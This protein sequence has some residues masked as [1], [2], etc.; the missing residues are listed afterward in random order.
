MK[1]RHRDRENPENEVG[2]ILKW[3]QVAYGIADLIDE[4]KY[5]DDKESEEYIA[6]LSERRGTDENRVKAIARHIAEDG[7]KRNENG[8]RTTFF[9]W[10]YADY[11]FC[12]DHAVEIE[13]ALNACPEVA[14]AKIDG[15]KVEITVKEA[16][17][18]YS[19]QPS[20]KPVRDLDSEEDEEWKS[21]IESGEIKPIEPVGESTKESNTDLTKIGFEQSELGGVKQRFKNNIEA[22]KLV[23][24]L[25]NSQKEATA[26]EKKVLANTSVGAAWRKRSTNIMSLGKANM[27]N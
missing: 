25:I 17:R 5:F 18:R 21:R 4:D 26:D 1:L 7:V 14:T 13:K 10:R 8:E 22:I 16:Y 15:D 27:R 6:F 2:M 3:E 20:E 19:E 23:N 11:K 24:R 9:S 12:K